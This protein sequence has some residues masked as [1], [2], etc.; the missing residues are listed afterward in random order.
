MIKI[1]E[2]QKDAVLA[3]VGYTRKQLDSDLEHMKNWLKIQHHLP[4]SRLTESDSFLTMFLTGCKG[5]LEKAKRKIDAYYTFRS[6]SELFDSR[7]P[8]DP[9][10]VKIS[11]LIYFTIL[12]ALSKEKS[13]IFVYGGVTYADQEGFDFLYYL[14]LFLSASEVWLREVGYSARVYVLAD[15]E[16]ATVNPHLLMVKP[17][18]VKDFIYYALEALPHRYVKVSFINTPPFIATFFNH[19]VIPFVS[20]KIKERIHVTANGIEEI[21]Q[22]FDKTSLPTDCGGDFPLYQMNEMWRA[23]EIKRRDWFVNELSERCDES[24]RIIP[25]DPTNPYFGV[26]G[27]L[28]KLVVD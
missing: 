17:L 11:E 25:Q 10:Y 15:F 27:S 5:S 4:P 20:K 7:D 16:R 22:D 14:R 13:M 3:E 8:L 6:H 23:E 21:I 9:G 26:P 18:L 28:K 2:E 1:T 19:A 12:P 24:K